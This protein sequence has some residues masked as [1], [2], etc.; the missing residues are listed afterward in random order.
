VAELIFGSPAT[1]LAANVDG[2]GANPYGN[3][4]L[5]RQDTG[6]TEI[7]MTQLQVAMSREIGGWPLYTIVIALGQVHFATFTVE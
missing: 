4:G 5:S 1:H 7:I 2:D 3:G 6:E